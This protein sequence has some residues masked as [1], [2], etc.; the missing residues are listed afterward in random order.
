M[1]EFSTEPPKVGCAERVGLVGTK[2]LGNGQ[3]LWLLSCSNSSR[4]ELPSVA[5]SV[6]STRA[7]SSLCRHVFCTSLLPGPVEGVH[8]LPRLCSQLDAAIISMKQD[9]P[10]AEPAVAFS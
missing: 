1:A 4:G 9:L 3:V 6:L 5:S 7:T 8:G 2:P 10:L